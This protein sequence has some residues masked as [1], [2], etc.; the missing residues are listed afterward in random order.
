MSPATRFLAE[1]AKTTNL[2]SAEICASSLPLP[3]PAL[4]TWP[5]EL[6]ETSVSVPVCRSFTKMSATALESSAAKPVEVLTK[7]T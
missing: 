2:P 1:L 7:A 6:R 4:A 3:L 5:S